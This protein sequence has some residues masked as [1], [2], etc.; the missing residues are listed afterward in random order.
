MDR[1]ENIVKNGRSSYGYGLGSTE[2]VVV[3]HGGHGYK[4][5][6]TNRSLSPLNPILKNLDNFNPSKSLD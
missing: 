2:R 1:I 6:E 4:K 3:K 5:S